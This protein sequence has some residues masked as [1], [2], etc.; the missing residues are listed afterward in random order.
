MSDT[1]VLGAGMV[2]VSSALA[3][4]DA[5]YDVLLLDKAS[6]GTK[7]SYGNAGIIQTEAAE[8]Y[9]WPQDLP[10]LLSYAFE[11]SNDVVWE[12]RATLTMSSALWRY[13]Y[14]SSPRRHSQISTIYSRLTAA[15]TQDHSPYIEATDSHALIAK[16]GLFMLYR[17]QKA[18]DEANKKAVR[19]N[20][21]YGVNYRTY[22]G[23]EYR[24]L[25]PALIS[26]PAGGIHWTDSWSCKDPGIL[27]QRYANLFM[28]RG[29]EIRKT[30]ATS[31]V[32]TTNGWRVQSTD[33]SLEAE[34]VVICLGHASPDFLKPIGYRIPMIYKRGYH[35]HYNCK[36]A[37]KTPFLDVDNGV[38]AANMTKGL[39]ITTGAALVNTEAP[40]TTK[41]LKRG[42]AAIKTLLDLGEPVSEPQWFGTRPCLPDMLPLVGA[43]PHHRRL[44]YNFGHGHQGFTLGP[45]TAKLLVASMQGKPSHLADALTP[46]HRTWLGYHPTE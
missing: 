34:H 6:P 12:S 35:G 38:L 14:Y 26:T 15:S 29:G 41:Q 24:A 22:S 40:A 36:I 43:A 23:E 11:T 30:N 16:T 31:I 4:Q 21:T 45:T 1:I 27:T 32:E 8:P 39:R 9:A 42:T 33:S 18:F 46:E 44:W 13:S 7:A 19:I 2:G 5:G 17:T 37:P 28:Q 20:K 10:T 3:L 25:E